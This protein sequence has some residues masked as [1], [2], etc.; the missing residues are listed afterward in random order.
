[1]KNFFKFPLYILLLF[2]TKTVSAAHPDLRTIEI[3]GSKYVCHQENVITLCPDD[4]LY[5]AIQTRIDQYDCLQQISS[6]P[7]KERL[8]KCFISPTYSKYFDQFQLMD[9]PTKCIVDKTLRCLESKNPCFPNE[10]CG[11]LGNF[12]KE[13]KTY[14]FDIFFNQ[15][16]GEAA[17]K[18]LVY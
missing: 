9:M 13:L 8:R 11:F 6:S 7:T 10:D 17:C 15:A 2:V 1:M 12:L 4:D 14:K 3:D 5:L 18:S 16:D